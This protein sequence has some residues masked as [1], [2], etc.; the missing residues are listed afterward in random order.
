MSDLLI[1]APVDHLN[2]LYQEQDEL[3]AEWAPTA[4]EAVAAERVKYIRLV[5]RKT[6]MSESESN[7]S[8]F[9][10]PR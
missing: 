10:S 3:E 2:M 1:Q 8:G 7:P 9:S 4:D 6:Y 5:K